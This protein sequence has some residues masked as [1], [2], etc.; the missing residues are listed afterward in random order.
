MVPVRR[1]R[2]ATLVVNSSSFGAKFSSSST[3]VGLRFRLAKVELRSRLGSHD[4]VVALMFAVD[5]AGALELGSA[6]G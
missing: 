3:A 5:S 4:C 1:P 2:G 6:Y